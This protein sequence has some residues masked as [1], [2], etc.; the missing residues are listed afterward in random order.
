MVMSGWLRGSTIGVRKITGCGCGSSRFLR[1]LS[2]C[3]GNACTE[4]S[5]LLLSV[6]AASWLPQTFALAFGIGL[7]SDFGSWIKLCSKN[8]PFLFATGIWWTW[9]DQNN[10]IFYPSNLWKSS[11][12]LPLSPMVKINCDASILG[13]DGVAG[14]T[15]FELSFFASRKG[16][17][18]AWEAGHKLV[19]CETDSVLVYTLTQQVHQNT[20]GEHRD[21]LLKI[22]EVFNW[23]WIA[24]V[25]LIQRTTSLAANHMAC[26]TAV[27]RQ[28]YGEWTQPWKALSVIINREIP[29]A[30]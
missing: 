1:K 7:L 3:F 14:V 24:G 28:E 5:Q 18:L 25:H 9:H 12:T 8:H 23:N 6:T 2:F 11:K 13:N 17:A 19:L 20:N 29:T 10:D 4:Q 27:I 30:P 26:T 22:R 15:S 21:L 16:L